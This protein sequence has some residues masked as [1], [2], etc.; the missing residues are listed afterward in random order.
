MALYRT[1]GAR[2]ESSI[3]R[4]PES[5]LSQAADHNAINARALVPRNVVGPQD[6]A[7]GIP[8]FMPRVI[9]DFTAEHDACAVLNSSMHVARFLHW[10]AFRW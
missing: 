7:G 10:T 1:K 9:D 4:S 5:H 2:Q 6:A 3:P 8:S